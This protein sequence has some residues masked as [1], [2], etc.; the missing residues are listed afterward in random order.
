MSLE[1]VFKPTL[2]PL[3]AP[4]L[5]LSFVV[6]AAKV[7]IKLPDA[8]HNRALSEKLRRIDFG[9]SITLVGAVGCLLFGFDLK[10]TEDMEWTHPLFLFFICTSIVFA[11]MFLVTE[12]YCAPFP[13]MPLQLVTQRTPLFVSLSNLLL[14]MGVYSMVSVEEEVDSFMSH[15]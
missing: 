4:I 5:I 11:F 3:Q 14:S 8:I 6:V 12:R 10:T 2:F 7:N 15:L 1:N 9:G 13:V